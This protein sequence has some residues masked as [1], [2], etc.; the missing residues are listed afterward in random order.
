MYRKSKSCYDGMMCS[1]KG[2]WKFQIRKKKLLK[3]VYIIANA[4]QFLEFQ[5]ERTGCTHSHAYPYRWFIF[6]TFNNCSE[7][8]GLQNP[9]RSWNSE[10]ISMESQVSLQILAIPIGVD[11]DRTLSSITAFKDKWKCS[12]RSS[13]EITWVRIWMNMGKKTKRIFKNKNTFLSSRSYR[14]KICIRSTS[15]NYFYA[16]VT[17]VIFIFS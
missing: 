5:N 17:F 13:C 8:W 14:L 15:W 3:Y 16:V 2:V 11:I 6:M 12:C 9:F 7:S 1:L 4:L 10:D